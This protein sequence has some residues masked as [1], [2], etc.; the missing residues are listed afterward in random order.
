MV[1][2]GLVPDLTPIEAAFSKLKAL[3][4]TAAARPH[5]ALVA[6]IWAALAAL[7]PTEASSSFTHYGYPAQAQLS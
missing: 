7:T 3:L 1:P 2:A 5:E 6:A 4:R